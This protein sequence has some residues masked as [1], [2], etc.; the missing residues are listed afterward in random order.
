MKK[1]KKREML[2]NAGLF[3]ARLYLNWMIKCQALLACFMWL[4]DYSKNPLIWSF[5]ESYV[6]SVQHIWSVNFWYFYKISPVQ[7]WGVC[8]NRAMRYTVQ[9]SKTTR[10]NVIFSFNLILIWFNTSAYQFEW[11]VELK[12]QI[13]FSVVSKM[14]VVCNERHY[15]LCFSHRLLK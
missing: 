12:S 14:N 10:K 15:N 5:R 9:T 3:A 2:M 13:F 7:N 1:K 6:S 8:T 11:K 4:M